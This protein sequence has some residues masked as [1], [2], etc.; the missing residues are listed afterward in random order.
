MNLS[1]SIYRSLKMDSLSSIE[2]KNK[3]AT[4]ALCSPI[5]SAYLHQMHVNEYNRIQNLK[6]STGSVE[7]E[8]FDHQTLEECNDRWQSS[9][10]KIL[11]RENE[12]LKTSSHSLQQEHNKTIEETKVLTEQNT[13][14]KAEMEKSLTRLVIIEQHTILGGMHIDLVD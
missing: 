13:R 11:E 1:K 2:S 8:I 12:L 7:A 9:N 3:L 10:S 4:E 14:L 5:S 6:Q